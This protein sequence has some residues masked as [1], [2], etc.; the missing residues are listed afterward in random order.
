MVAEVVP[1][2]RRVEAGAL[3][4][5]SAPMGLFLATY[6]VAHRPSLGQVQIHQDRAGE[7][8]Y[9]IRPGHYFAAMDDLAYLENTSRQ[10]LGDG[11]TV[12]WELVEEL[13]CE[14]SGKFLFSRSTVTPAFLQ[15]VSS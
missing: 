6:V 9:R 3:L 12:R 8:L 14:P 10:Y 5:T 2:R 11:V 4:Y 7:V 15:A 13:P 1:E